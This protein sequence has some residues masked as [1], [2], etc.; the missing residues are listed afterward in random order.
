MARLATIHSTLSATG[1][2]RCPTGLAGGNPYPNLTWPNFNVGNYPVLSSGLL[3]PGASYTFLDP[4]ARPPRVLQWS[5]GLQREVQKDVVVEA[6]Y[7]GNREVWG[8]AT[9]E[10]QIA[11]NSLNNTIL[12]HY[13]ISLANPADRAL[14]TSLIGSPQAIAAGFGPAYPGMPPTQTIAQ[15]LRPVPQ[16]NN[17]ERRSG[18]AHRQNLVRLAADQ[19]HQALLA[20][21]VGAGLVR[22]VQSVGQR[23]GVGSRQYH[24]PRRCAH[25]QRYLQLWDQ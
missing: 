1:L 13:G 2:H 5:F 20:R 3:P 6:T 7:V 24:E 23:H 22:L 9:A 16:W 21:L 12:A 18:P 17:G 19:G 10:D 8:A 11:S 15:Q 4:S 25:L 14:L